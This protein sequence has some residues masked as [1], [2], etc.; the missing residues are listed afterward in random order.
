MQGRHGEPNAQLALLSRR[1]VG[2]VGFAEQQGRD[3]T[4]QPLD[5][6]L[7]DLGDALVFAAEGLDAVVDGPESGLEPDIQRRCD[8]EGCV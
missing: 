2:G 5:A 6:S 3:E 7:V 8:R 4:A 1:G